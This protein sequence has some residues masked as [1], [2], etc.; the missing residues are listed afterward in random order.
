[1]GAP[2]RGRKGDATKWLNRIAQGFYE[3]ELVKSAVK[4]KFFGFESSCAP[5]SSDTS[6][7]TG[8]ME[9]SAIG[10]VFAG[11]IVRVGKLLF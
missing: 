8:S 9:R 7:V 11:L 10:P 3:A 6:P 4:K 2:A 5:E 1:M